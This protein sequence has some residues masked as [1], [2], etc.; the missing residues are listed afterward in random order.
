MQGSGFRV[1]LLGEGEEGEEEDGV[2]AICET[3]SAIIEGTASRCTDGTTIG[4]VSG[5]GFLGL[6]FRV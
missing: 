6:G 3:K 4:G 5:H 1:Y 2:F